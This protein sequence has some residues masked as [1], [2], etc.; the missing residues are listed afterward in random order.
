M[1][2][3]EA[4]S[5]IRVHK[6]LYHTTAEGF[7]HRACIWVQGCHRHC[8]GCMS[9]HTWD[10]DK[11]T[12]LD[13]EEITECILKQNEIEGITLLGGEPFEQAEELAEISRVCKEHGLSVIAFSGYT[14]KE[15]RCSKQKGIQKLLVQIDL[16]IDGSY[17]EEQR[18]LSR[19][20]VGSSN[21][22]FC[23]LTERYSYKDIYEQKNRMEIRITKDGKIIINGMGDLEQSIREEDKI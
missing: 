22:Q 5:K 21:Q 20:W 6:I 7:G 18:D 13:T 8:P 2:G 1:Q 16:L 19:P 15:L 12:L 3:I 23:F 9:P 10:P 11:G 4:M 17:V 14:L